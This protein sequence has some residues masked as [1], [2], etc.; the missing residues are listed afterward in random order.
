MSAPAGAQPSRPAARFDGALVDAEVERFRAA[1]EVPGYAV[2]VVGATPQP[3]LKG[4]GVRTLGRSGAVGP[5]TR[6]AIA[7]NTKAYT[8]AAL[9][10]LVDEGRL[11]WDDPVL[12]HLPEFRMND[13]AV[14][15]MM[16][17]RDL[18]CHRSGLPLGAGDLLFFPDTTHR[19]PDALKAL[20]YLKAE[21]PFRG[22]YAYDNI[23]Y[24][25]AGLLIARVSGTSWRDFIGTRLLRPIGETDA[26]AGLDLLTSDDVAGRHGRRGGRLLG[27]GAMTVVQPQGEHGDSVEAAGGI[28][29]SVSDQARWLMT[30]LAR[31][32]APDGR[33]IW[34]AAQSEQMWT[35]QVITST[36]D[37]PTP[38]N[39]VRPVLTSYALGWGVSDYRGERIL[40]HAGGLNGQITQTAM[41][42]R[43]GLGV[44]VFSNAEENSTRGLRNAIL[45]HLLG[46]PKVDWVALQKADDDASQALKKAAAGSFDKQPAGGPALPLQ[47]YVGR[48]RDPWYGDMVVSR[49]GKGLEIAFLPT[50]DFEGPLEP[51]GSDTFRTRF[52][53]GFEDALVRFVVGGGRVQEVT[54]KPFSPL[55]DFS[56]DFQHLDF[57]PVMSAT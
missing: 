34:S 57:R 15:P 7:S 2:A 46:A 31:G 42:P 9:A 13:P 41:L 39:P 11:G 35:P 3:Y 18:L 19:A 47:A 1:F 20:P 49:R 21:R 55:A 48:Y 17:V 10:I 27:E 44:V 32:V 30:Q 52:S 6:F 25:V 24:T 26:V 36:S 54:M 56:N 16:T 23:L 8:A 37:G 50:P 28:N 5:H 38:Q 4:Y 12:R 29:A 33:R 45:D 51:W 53:P 40:T 14:T 43:R 22:G